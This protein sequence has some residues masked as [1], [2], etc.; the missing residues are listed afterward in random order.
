[1]KIR[2]HE[3]PYQY[4]FQYA[5]RFEFT[6]QSRVCYHKFN[7]IIHYELQ[8]RNS[9]VSQWWLTPVINIYLSQN[10][11]HVWVCDDK[12]IFQHEWGHLN[13]S[14]NEHQLFYFIQN[15]F[16]LSLLLFIYLLESSFLMDSHIWWEHMN[17]WMVIHIE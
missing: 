8:N 4:Y 9:S 6:I 5:I 12:I 11:Q 17:K 2:A 15:E 13:I 10:N 1:M 16:F 7:Q 3:N 14:I